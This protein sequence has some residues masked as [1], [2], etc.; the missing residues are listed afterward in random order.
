[1]ADAHVDLVDIPTSL[2]DT[3][4]HPAEA[5]H[6]TYI[7]P[8]RLAHGDCEGKAE[9]RFRVYHVCQPVPRCSWFRAKDL[10]QGTRY[11]QP[12]RT[13]S[14]EPVAIDRRVGTLPSW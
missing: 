13:G 4:I 11:L 6:S 2:H 10:E 14:K 12:Y 1:M 5:N 8:H 9:N 7:P 3:I